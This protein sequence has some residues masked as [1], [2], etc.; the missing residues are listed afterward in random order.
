LGLKIVTSKPKF[1]PSNEI[2][3]V[4]IDTVPAKAGSDEDEKSASDA[5]GMGLLPWAFETPETKSRVLKIAMIL[6]IIRCPL[7]IICS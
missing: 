5:G 4:A 6:R 1:A 7:R 2:G 3:G